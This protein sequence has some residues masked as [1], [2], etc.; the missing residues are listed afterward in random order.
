VQSNN[1]SN[2]KHLCAAAEHV[3]NDKLSCVI[4]GNNEVL[5]QANTVLLR[6]T[7]AQYRSV[8]DAYGCSSIGQHFRHI[9]DM[10]RAVTPALSA[11]PSPAPIIDYDVRRRGAAVETERKSAI[12]ELQDLKHALINRTAPLDLQVEVKTEVCIDSTRCASMRSTLARELA[13][14][15]SHAV[16]HFALIQL[17]ARLLGASVDKSVGLAPASAS[18][19]RAEQSTISAVA[20]S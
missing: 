14:I 2:I 13:F 17:L 16:H 5:G 10:Y 3:E 9:L 6:L 1:P 7:D 4:D 8:N 19:Q 18:H 11:A 15:S 20:T 12:A